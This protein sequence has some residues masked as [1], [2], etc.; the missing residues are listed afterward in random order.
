MKSMDDE[1][2]LESG[3]TQAPSGQ[4]GPASESPAAAESAPLAARLR[5]RS[6]REILGQDQLVG[7]QGA[8]KGSLE[9][10]TLPSVVLVGPPGSGKTTIAQL[11]ARSQSAHLISLSAVSAGVAEIRRAVVDARTRQRLGQRTV[12]FLDE[13]HHF[14]RTQQDAL[15]PYVESGLLTLIGATT[16]NP[17]F[18]LTGALLSRVQVLELEPLTADA[19]SELLDRALAD[20]EVGLGG[21][22]LRLEDQARKVLV[23][24]SGGDARVMLNALE[25]AAAEVG[26]NGVLD[27]AAALRALSSPVLRHDRAGDLHYQLLSAFIKSMRGS[28]PDASVYWL[29]RLLEAGE[30]PLVPARRMVILAAEDVGLAEPQAL[31]MAV[32]AHSAAQLVG[33]PECRL[34]LTEAAIFLALAPKSNSVISA[35]GAAAEDVRSR[36]HLSVPPHLRNAVTARDRQRGFGKGYQYA[37]DDPQALV[38]HEHLPAELTG[39]RYYRPSSHGEEVALGKRLEETR[40]RRKG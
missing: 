10:G 33:M 32:A 28:D 4:V 31:G 21:Q 34:P 24:R 18:Q 40:S 39:H 37:H 35:Y 12:L 20:Q 13:I 25:Q 7:P 1:L 5:P 22:H 29:A 11:L 19:L 27:E 3:P 30:D 36:L 38:S 14:S 23:A 26:A 6:W 9:G 8:L 16:E 15:L 17:S 2:P